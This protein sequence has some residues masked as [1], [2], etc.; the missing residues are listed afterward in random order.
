MLAQACDVDAPPTYFW[1]GDERGRPH[2]AADLCVKK[3]RGLVRRFTGAFSGY[4]ISFSDHVRVADFSPRL[5]VWSGRAGKNS[6]C[7][8]HLHGTSGASEIERDLSAT[9]FPRVQ[10]CVGDPR[11][12][13]TLFQFGNKK[14][15]AKGFLRA[16]LHVGGD[17][18]GTSMEVWRVGF[19]SG[20]HFR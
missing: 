9:Q 14:V 1:R 2:L 6:A 5:V 10:V 20:A 11:D 3:V 17:V 7:A 18:N 13:L 19:H 4:E 8:R 12:L 16:L 15:L